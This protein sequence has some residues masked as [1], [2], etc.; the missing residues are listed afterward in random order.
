MGR[1]AIP[2]GSLL[3]N[4][5]TLRTWCG[6]A[7]CLFMAFAL[8]DNVLYRPCTLER[9]LVQNTI[10]TSAQ[11]DLTWNCPHVR[12][13]AAP[14]NAVSWLGLASLAGTC[15]NSFHYDFVSEAADSSPPSSPFAT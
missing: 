5:L 12:L 7:L 6:L 13:T 4:P 2:S 10:S 1:T 8:V 3:E 11:P 14:S 9:H 15:P